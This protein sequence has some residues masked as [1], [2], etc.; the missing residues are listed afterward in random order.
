VPASGLGGEDLRTIAEALYHVN[1]NMQM[2]E[3]TQAIGAQPAATP[4]QAAEASG[5]TR[6]VDALDFARLPLIG[7]LR[8][9][10]A[11]FNDDRKRLDRY[12]DEAIGSGDE[13]LVAVSWMMR[14]TLAENDGDVAALRV[15]AAGALQRYR[16]L[17]ERWG[18]SNALRL[19]G[20]LCML[21]GDL[22]GAT[23]AYTEALAALKELG[24]RDDEFMLRLQLADLATRRGEPAQAREGF[25]SALAAV[26]TGGWGPDEAMIL[27][28]GARFEVAAGN[29]IRARELYTSAAARLQGISHSSPIWHHLSTIVQ[30]AGAM[31]ALADGDLTL[32]QER[33]AAAQQTAVAAADMPLIASVALVAAELALAFENPVR[34]AELLAASAVVRGAGDPT[35]ME[36]RR[37]G[38]RLRLAL[39]DDVFAES[40][41]QGAELSRAAA[42]ELLG[43]SLAG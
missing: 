33:A 18:L 36:V 3:P 20:T 41:A 28:A 19:V 39:G 1:Q 9:M 11:F 43:S 10:Y 15:T 25:E 12:I 6:R 34:A 21:D 16:V 40:Q 2:Y 38:E 17:G 8:E 13:W 14:A 5:L 24:S 27:A 37:L 35:A 26:Q 7:L 42:L 32:A 22:D 4:A 23:A 31:V 29:T 30:S